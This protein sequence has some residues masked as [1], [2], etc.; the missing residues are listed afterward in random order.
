[1]ADV[2][3]LEQIEKIRA[4]E[5]GYRASHVINTGFRFGILNALAESVEGL[6]SSELAVK[7]MLHE[8]YLK[9][10]CQTAYHFEILDSDH[11]GRFRLQPFMEEVLGLDVYT[12]S[13]PAK[14]NEW[15]NATPND[16]LDRY[17]KTGRVS[18]SFKSPEASFATGR[19]A[20][21]MITVFLSMIFPYC[22]ELK[23]K[24]EDGVKLLDIGCGSG[25]LLIDLAGAFKNSCFVGIDSDEH[26]IEKADR[27]ITTLG[28]NDRIHVENLN[29]EDMSFSE[30]FDMAALVLTLHEILPEDRPVALAKAHRALKKDGRLMI[31]DYPY[32]GRLEDFRNPR[33][34]YGIVEQYFEAINGIVHIDQQQQD[35]LLCEAG[36]KDIRRMA[37]SEGGMLDFLSVL[38]S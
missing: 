27:D 17:I 38:K 12:Q 36:F 15:E 16:P 29:A 18:Q 32:P 14:E 8:P 9:V 30:E 28:L 19:A 22:E 5:K 31:L 10:W 2:T 20:K 34:E 13:P 23:K 6:T 33:Y 35:E 1:M 24:L 26:G 7:L 25:N 3:I 11:Q 4:F 21:S 37:V